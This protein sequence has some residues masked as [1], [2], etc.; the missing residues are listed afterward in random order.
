MAPSL[1][2]AV[3]VDIGLREEELQPT[4]IGSLTRK[5]SWGDDIRTE[6]GEIGLDLFKL[7]LPDGA[8]SHRTLQADR[9]AVVE[10]SLKRL[11]RFKL[12]G[13]SPVDLAALHIR[14]GVP[15]VWNQS[16]LAQMSKAIEQSDM[17]ASTNGPRA[18]MGFI[19]EPEAAAL[20]TIPGLAVK[21]NLKDVTSYTL[22]ATSPVTVDE[23]VQCEGALLGDMYMKGAL[24]SFVKREAQT[25]GM[26]IEKVD[27][28]Q[29]DDRFEEFWEQV[30]TTYTSTGFHAAPHEFIL[31]GPDG[32]DLPPLLLKQLAHPPL[33]PYVNYA[34]NHYL[35]RSD[36]NRELRTVTNE[37]VSLMERQVEAVK[38]KK[39]SPPNVRLCFLHR[40]LMLSGPSLMVLT[41]PLA[42][43]CRR[44]FWVQPIP[45]S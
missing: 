19:S 39:G 32:Q 21:H 27:K 34:P 44:R 10:S 9:L 15:A 43:R 2:L 18:T 24:L 14:F 45:P 33:K 29:F 22:T 7:A 23:C 1:K 30:R 37:I 8:L 40:R 36:V 6:Q 28:A 41:A 3:G 5:E 12:D 16:T 35:G 13:L 26:D 38:K 17:L 25:Y 4:V 20:A 42:H 31:V 11:A